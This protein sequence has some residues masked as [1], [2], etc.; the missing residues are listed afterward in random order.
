MFVLD[1]FEN[2]PSGQ[3]FTLI[4]SSISFALSL[5]VL[6]DASLLGFSGF[7]IAYKKVMILYHSEF[8]GRSLGVT[9]KTD[10]ALRG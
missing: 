7:L 5:F 2:R 8:G 6:F 1:C 9:A 10:I 3:H 4:L